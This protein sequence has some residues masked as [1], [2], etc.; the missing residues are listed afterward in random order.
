M[1]ETEK[2]F[3]KKYDASKYQKHSVAADI[4]IFST[5]NMENID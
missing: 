2:E 4:V 1:E 5:C 3:L